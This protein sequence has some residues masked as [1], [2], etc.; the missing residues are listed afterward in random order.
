MPGATAAQAPIL[1]LSAGGIDVARASSWVDAGDYE[2]ALDAWQRA[3]TVYN[4]LE[5][6]E[7]EVAALIQIAR[8]EH[9]L[10]NHCDALST[11]EIA[12]AVATKLG[13]T[14]SLIDAKGALAVAN[15]LMRNTEPA[16]SLLKEAMELAA[17]EDTPDRVDGLHQNLGNL[18]L[19]EQ[20]FSEA[21]EAYTSAWKSAQAADNVHLAT[22]ALAHRALA[23]LGDGRSDEAATWNEEAFRAIEARPPSRRKAR[24]LILVGRTSTGLIRSGSSEREA[25]LRRAADA[26]QQALDLAQRLGNARLE[27]YALGYLAEL[28]QLEDRH[29][30]ALNLCRRAVFSAQQLIASDL[31]YLWEWRRG[32][33]LRALGNADE[34]IA[35]LQRAVQSARLVQNALTLGYWNELVEFPFGPQ[36]REL[37]RDLVDLLIQ[38]AA[39]TEDPQRMTDA[40]RAARETIELFRALEV[41]DYF[42]DDCARLLQAHATPIEAIGEHAAVVYY[43]PLERRTEIIVGSAGELS[44]FSAPVGTARLQTL[45]TELRGLLE[46]RTTYEF[47]QPAAELHELLI[48][49]LD[50]YLASRSVDTLVFVPDAPLRGIPMSALHDGETFLIERYSIAVSPSLTL[51]D[52]NPIE[53]KN[54]SLLASALSLPVQDLPPLEYARIEVATIRTNFPALV[55]LDTEFQKDRL[56]TE[57][58]KAQYSILHVASHG[59]FDR[60]SKRSYLLTYEDRLSLDDLEQLIR[61]KQYRG[62]PL[63]LLV[64]SA[65]ETAVGDNRAALGLAGVAVKSGARSAVATLWLVD[66]QASS[67]LT[68]EF[69]GQLRAATHSSKAKALQAAQVSLLNDERYRH[70]YYWS[71]YLVIGNWL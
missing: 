48:S 27:S 53:R 43:I 55:L 42:R 9:L 12:H 14:E 40:L 32:T 38:R 34:A 15:T 7:Q 18:F 29:Q 17:Q 46:K 58:A 23:A 70:P 22:A 56:F 59:H 16:H 4:T 31:L 13:E 30:E 10:G 49:P 52:P 6:R 69:Y 47:L 50:A 3:A 44:R 2:K 26:F 28:Y 8:V 11:C 20:R 63:E 61:P 65:C 5:Q 39:V 68:Q 25:E 24:Q 35:A 37:Y 33:S 71:P 1:E 19:S 21:S 67:L 45:A 62:R 41:E 60:D 36:P 66:D 51:M 57:F 64:L 54:V